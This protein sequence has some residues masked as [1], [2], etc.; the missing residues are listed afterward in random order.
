MAEALEF[1]ASESTD[2]EI[3]ANELLIISCPERYFAYNTQLF[4]QTGGAIKNDGKQ[5]GIQSVH[6]ILSMVPSNDIGY[7]DTANS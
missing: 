3:I 6:E 2:C 4:K 5:I 7:L 1:A